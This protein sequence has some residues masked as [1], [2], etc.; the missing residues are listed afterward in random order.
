MMNTEIDSLLGKLDA[1]P[2]SLL[3]ARLADA[4]LQT[5][6]MNEAIDVCEQGLAHHTDYANGHMIMAKCYGRLGL[7][8]QAKV[9]LQRAL[10]LDNGHVAALI[11]LG[12]IYYEEKRIDRALH[13]YRQAVNVDPL[14]QTVRKRISSVKGG[15][16]LLTPE[17]E[18][19]ERDGGG[20]EDQQET[21]ATVT[22]AE[23]Y[24][25]QGLTEKAIDMF[26]RV[27][28]CSPDREDIVYRIRTL[29][30]QLQQEE[31]GGIYGDNR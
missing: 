18:S 26:R 7:R 30:E 5:D 28:S 20:Q 19:H 12:D 25:S 16:T 4:Y 2:G 3:F 22:L 13:C 11:N 24:A 31:Q 27:L 1:H 21:I 6:K 23:I 9:E 17:Q 10:E 14:S 15:G 29:E 8:D